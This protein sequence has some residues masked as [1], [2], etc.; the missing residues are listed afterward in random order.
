[1][2]TD[3]TDAALLARRDSVFRKCH[4]ENVDAILGCLSECSEFDVVEF[5]LPLHVSDDTDRYHCD[6]LADKVSRAGSDSFRLDFSESDFSRTEYEKLSDDERL[7]V[8][9]GRQP[10]THSIVV[11]SGDWQATPRLAIEDLVRLRFLVEFLRRTGDADF[12]DNTLE[13]EIRSKT[14]AEMLKV[15]LSLKP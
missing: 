7:R 13:D 8:D 4:G 2:K 14:M 9:I 15:T 12:D 6:M 11:R 5:D 10:R 1:M 3:L